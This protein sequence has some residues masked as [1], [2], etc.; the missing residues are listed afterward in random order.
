MTLL[1]PAAF[2]AALDRGSA[3]VATGPAEALVNDTT[4]DTFLRMSRGLS[5]ILLAV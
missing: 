2:F 5:I 3:S 4:R 1:L